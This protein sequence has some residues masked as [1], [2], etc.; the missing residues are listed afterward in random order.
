MPRLL[1]D[2]MVNTRVSKSPSTP[3][4]D[5]NKSGSNNNKEK[6]TS[7]KKMK[8]TRLP[9]A[10]RPSAKGD[11]VV[12]KRKLSSPEEVR[13]VKIVRHDPDEPVVIEDEEEVMEDV[14]E[15]GE[16]MVEIIPL[17][18][19]N[20]AHPLEESISEETTDQ[21]EIVQEDGEDSTPE[22]TTTEEAE[23]PDQLNESITN[24]DGQSS[25][26]TSGD[27]AEKPATDSIVD[28]LEPPINP[29]GKPLTPRQLE[30]FMDKKKRHEERLRQKVER[31]KKLE[32]E[33]RQKEERERQKKKERE[34]KEEQKRK[35]KEEKEVQRA[36]EKEDRE[37]KKQEELDLKRQR[38]EQ[39]KEEK[40][41]RDEQMEEERRKKEE[42]K[43]KKELEEELKKK[44]ASQA[45]TKF[46][47]MGPKT[48]EEPPATA[49]A[50]K[51]AEEVTHQ[52]FMPFEVKGDMK[53][54]PTV[55]RPFLG[56][57]KSTLD[58]HLKK[59][60]E[61]GFCYLKLLKTKKHVPLKGAKTYS[62]SDSTDSEDDL[63]VVGKWRISISLT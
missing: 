56:N 20:S 7:G 52:Y 54:A 46:F 11:S 13:E 15:E 25:E 37:R 16:E 30:K 10:Q 38:D 61:P 3:N 43:R 32:D 24:L 27:D 21:V 26:S 60:V 39:K 19:S 49:D 5:N 2:A 50:P 6:T 23:E 59:T 45:F 35:E 22:A 57:A 36:K 53:L 14:I 40:R 47:K 1:G 58:E 29:N 28:L 33:R 18:E 48:E 42:E 12:R 4:Q 17:D 31:E 9:F 34:E 62:S 8:Q 41:K 63:M 55:R 51:A 44:R